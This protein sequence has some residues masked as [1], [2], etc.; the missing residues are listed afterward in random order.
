MVRLLNIVLQST[1]KDKRGNQSK[2]LLY[3]SERTK[4]AMNSENMYIL[5][6]TKGIKNT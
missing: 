5:A 2:K 4:H 3:T 6:L 1:Q